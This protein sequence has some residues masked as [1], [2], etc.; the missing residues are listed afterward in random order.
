[1]TDRIACWRV[2]RWRREA[3]DRHCDMLRDALRMV[4]DHGPTLP[5]GLHQHACQ[6]L[7]A[8]TRRERDKIGTDRISQ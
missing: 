3:A 5:P 6:V 1:M 8:T 7:A 2:G 4:L